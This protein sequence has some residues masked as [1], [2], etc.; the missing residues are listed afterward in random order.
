MSSL[1]QLCKI[2]YPGSLQINV[3]IFA[4]AAPT[5]NSSGVESK[6]FD[7]TGWELALVSTPSADISAVNDRQLVGLLFEFVI[8]YCVYCLW[9]LYQEIQE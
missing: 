8:I 6:D 7:P 3:C 9:L 4:D 2:L 5:F 1:F